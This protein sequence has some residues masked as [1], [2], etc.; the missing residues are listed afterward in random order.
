MTIRTRSMVVAERKRTSY[1]LHLDHF[2]AITMLFPIIIA[3]AFGLGMGT[4]AVPAVWTIAVLHIDPRVVTCPVWWL[5][6]LFITRGIL[7][8]AA[9]FWGLR[10]YWILKL[11]ALASL[12]YLSLFIASKLAMSYVNLP[13]KFNVNR[14][15]TLVF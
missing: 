9:L 15:L 3:R 12:C 5:V 8:Q 1:D 4:I 7:V 14:Y 6:S 13:E 11:H 2:R 10:G